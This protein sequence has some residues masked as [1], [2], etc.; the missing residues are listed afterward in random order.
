M[1][2][3]FFLIENQF[4]YYLLY[5]TPDLLQRNL[6]DQD[7]RNHHNYLQEILENPDRL[8]AGLTLV[9]P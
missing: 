7:I 1:C 8:I 5:Q 2:Q 6:Q 9:L 3:H 4:H